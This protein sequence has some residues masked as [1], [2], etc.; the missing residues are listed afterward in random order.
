LSAW[1]V[2]RQSIPLGAGRRPTTTPSRH[3]PWTMTMVGS[4]V[5]NDAAHS[6]GSESTRR[7]KQSL[8]PL[9]SWQAVP[10]QMELGDDDEHEP[11]NDNHELGIS[12]PT[13]TCTPA[14][15][16][17]PVTMRESIWNHIIGKSKAL[18][19]GQMLAFWL[20]SALSLFLFASRFDDC[21]RLTSWD[22]SLSSNQY[23]YRLQ[24]E[25]YNLNCTLIVIYQRRCF[26]FYASTFH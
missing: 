26:Q 12:T 21:N 18:V 15:E 1:S 17:Q 4:P 8:S 9:R 10:F 13:A 23:S 19:L 3:R 2:R 16:R 7:R 20:V 14:D 24:R 6:P 11:D 25:L 22:N 5:A